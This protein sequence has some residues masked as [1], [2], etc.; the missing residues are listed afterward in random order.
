M[1][2]LLAIRNVA[3]VATIVIVLGAWWRARRAKRRRDLDVAMRRHPAG[4]KK[5]S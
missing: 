2:V 4:K 3:V 1:D 5:D